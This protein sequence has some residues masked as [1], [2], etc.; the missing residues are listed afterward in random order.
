MNSSLEKI[1]E[2]SLY[3]RFG[4]CD[5]LADSEIESITGGRGVCD[6]TVCNGNGNG[7]YGQ[8]FWWS[9]RTRKIRTR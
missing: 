5:G 8:K 1:E 3:A 4:L 6:F 2:N 9:D 7:A